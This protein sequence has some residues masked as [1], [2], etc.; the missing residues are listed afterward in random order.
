MADSCGIFVINK[1]CVVSLFVGLN[2][3]HSNDESGVLWERDEPYTD[4]VTPGN[5]SVFEQAAGPG[6]P[7]ATFLPKACEC[8]EKLKPSLEAADVSEVAGQ[9]SS[10]VA[11]QSSTAVAGQQKERNERSHLKV[12]E[13]RLEA[14]LWKFKGENRKGSHFP[15][16]AFTGNVGRR[17]DERFRARK[18][19]GEERARKARDEERRWSS[20]EKRN[21]W[22]D[23]SWGWGSGGW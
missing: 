3:L 6:M 10:A 14:E 9:S 8:Y 13:K 20:W 19:R 5:F 4:A 16:C 11:G 18:A 17:S 1:P 23:A 2:R 12:N 21:W 7:L 15:I 22:S